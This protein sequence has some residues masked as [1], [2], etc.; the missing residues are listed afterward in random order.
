LVYEL[1]VYKFSLAEVEPFSR[2]EHLKL[3]DIFR[4]FCVNKKRISSGKLTFA[5]YAV[6]QTVFKLDAC[7]FR[8]TLIG[9]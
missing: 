7:P 2:D 5:A 3:D 8:M 6:N 4:L 9:I 1:K